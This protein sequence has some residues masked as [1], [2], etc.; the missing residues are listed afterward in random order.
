MKQSITNYASFDQYR[1]G[2]E[3]MNQ[4]YMGSL[5]MVHFIPK[6]WNNRP[7]YQNRRIYEPIIPRISEPTCQ[8]RRRNETTSSCVT[9]NLSQQ[10]WSNALK[11][12]WFDNWA[13]HPYR[14]SK[15][16]IGAGHPRW[17]MCGGPVAGFP[18]FLWLGG[19]LIQSQQSNASMIQWTDQP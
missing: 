13:S 19:G 18:I 3:W 7:S 17:L 16:V 5:S 10:Q 2:A 8:I 12:H 15:R 11:K 14:V 6:H 9:N 1:K 4:L